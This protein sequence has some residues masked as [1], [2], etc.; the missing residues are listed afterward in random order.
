L[1]HR[2]KGRVVVSLEVRRELTNSWGAIHGGVLMTLLDTSMAF[3]ARTAA[4]DVIGVMTVDMTASF[5][6]SAT[7][8]LV[9]EG[10]I[11]YGARSL[12]FCEGEARN[13]AGELIA[14]AIGT[15]M[16]KHAGEDTGADDERA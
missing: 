8:R 1:E 10:R 13:A 16:L 2:E 15:F 4:A 9:A 3:A 6:R 5:I 11:L 12:V 7:G 14:K